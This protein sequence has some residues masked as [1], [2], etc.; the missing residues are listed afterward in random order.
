MSEIKHFPFRAGFKREGQEAQ[1]IDNCTTLDGYLCKVSSKKVKGVW[2]NEFSPIWD[3]LKDKE[4]LSKRGYS[5]R[6][7]ID[8]HSEFLIKFGKVEGEY[9]VWNEDAKERRKLEEAK[10][11]YVYFAKSDPLDDECD[12]CRMSKK[13]Y[14]PTIQTIINANTRIVKNRSYLEVVNINSLTADLNAIGWQ[15]KTK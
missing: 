2:Q 13:N 4:T 15:I 10:T 14:P 11:V 5:M 12:E 9:W 7:A 3:G 6:Y 8:N 1:Y